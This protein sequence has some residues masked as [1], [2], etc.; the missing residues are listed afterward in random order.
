MLVQRHPTPLGIALVAAAILLFV[1][2]AWRTRWVFVTIAATG[3]LAAGFFY[4][5]RA[6]Q[7]ISWWMAPLSAILVG[8]PTAYLTRIAG[9][10]RE[11]K[12]AP[13]HL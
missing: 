11:N 10:A 3:L 6:P 7:H 13:G 9:R 12:R 1:V 8:F 5:L 4:L 2:D